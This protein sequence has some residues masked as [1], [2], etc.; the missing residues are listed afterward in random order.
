[1][2]SREPFFRNRLSQDKTYS[3]YS[4]LPLDL[5]DKV[6]VIKISFRICHSKQQ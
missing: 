1:M 3:T 5:F 2:T 4:P 6:H